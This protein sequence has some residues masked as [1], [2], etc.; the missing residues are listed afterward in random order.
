MTPEPVKVLGYKAFDDGEGGDD[1]EDGPECKWQMMQT[2]L[3]TALQTALSSYVDLKKDIDNIAKAWC[4]VINEA[5]DQSGGKKKVGGELYYLFYYWLGDKIWNTES[6]KAFFLTVMNEIWNALKGVLTESYEYGPI[7]TKD[8]DQIKFN[9]MKLAYEYYMDHKKIETQL[10]DAESVAYPCTL[11][12]NEHLKKTYS[13]YNKVYTSLYS[14]QS[15]GNGYCAEFQEMFKHYDN[16][17]PQE[18]KCKAIY[19]EKSTAD[20]GTIAAISSIVGI[21]ALPTITYVLYKITLPSIMVVDHLG[22][23]IMEEEGDMNNDNNNR[24]EII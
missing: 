5:Q 12:Y 3:K 1:M 17:N 2:K 9:E 23:Q 18:L 19:S 4:N 14:E 8:V 24:E 16:E 13:D 6:T 20:I 22:R 7:C 10:K 11:Q 15:S 21:G